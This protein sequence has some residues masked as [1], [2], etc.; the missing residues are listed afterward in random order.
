MFAFSHCIPRTKEKSL[1]RVVSS[2]LLLEFILSLRNFCWSIF[3]RFNFS[4]LF[5]ML[6]LYV[7]ISFFSFRFFPLFLSFLFINVSVFCKGLF[8][9]S[10]PLFFRIE[11]L[12][13]LF[14]SLSLSL[15]FCNV[16]YVSPF[17]YF[18]VPFLLRS[19]QSLCWLQNST[20]PCVFHYSDRQD[21]QLAL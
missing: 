21:I 3:R 11:L 18:C 12:V 9:L 20:V 19:P 1:L 2:L 4:Y 13:R 17:L 16:F 7:F 14:L 15:G 10:F 5:R 8:L 6:V